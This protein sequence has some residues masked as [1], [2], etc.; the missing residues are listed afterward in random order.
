MH[1]NRWVANAA[2]SSRCPDTGTY[3]SWSPE[4]MKVCGTI[5]MTSDEHVLFVHVV[6]SSRTS[7]EGGRRVCNARLSGLRRKHFRTGRATPRGPSPPP[8]PCGRR[9]CHS[10]KVRVWALA[11]NSRYARAAINK[12]LWFTRWHAVAVM[13]SAASEREKECKESAREP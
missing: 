4:F 9:L 13:V 11:G 2:A 1:R 10:C 6:V 12:S 7:H 8:A 5:V 3:G